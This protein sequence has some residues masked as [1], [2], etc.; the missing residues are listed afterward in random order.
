M[1]KVLEGFEQILTG[2]RSDQ[3]SGTGV[4]DSA[5]DCETCGNVVHKGAK[6]DSLDNAPDQQFNPFAI[7][8]FYA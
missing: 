2:G 3:N 5:G 6:A 8:L 7:K 4:T 1:Q